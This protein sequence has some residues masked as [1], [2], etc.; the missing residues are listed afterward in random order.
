MTPTPRRFSRPLAALLF[1]LLG[2]VASIFQTSS[3]ADRVN[4]SPALSDSGQLT[5]IGPRPSPSEPPV[6]G[7]SMP[8]FQAPEKPVVKE[9]ILLK[10]AR[11]Q[12]PFIKLHGNLKAESS[13]IKRLPLLDVR[14]KNKPTI[15]K[16]LRIGVVR[17]LSVPL[18]PIS[19]GA[20]YYVSEGEV[21]VAAILSA[22]SLR[23]RLHFTDTSLP[24]GARVFVY[25]MDNPE[26]FYGPYEGH[27]PSEDGTFWTPPLTGEG[28][29]VEYFTPSGA[30]SADPPFKISEISHNYKDVPG[31]TDSAGACNLE[32]S[33]EWANVAKS[34]GMI[35]FVT[36]GFEAV[37]TGTL[38]NDS[39]TS[40]DH[41][42]LTANHC[43]NS[44]SEAQS[45]QIYWNYNSGETPYTFP[46]SFSATLK[47]TG[48]ASDFSLLRFGSVPSGLF[49]SGWDANPVAASTTITG[50]HHPSGSHK[51][52]SF[53]ATNSNCVS[54]LPGPCTNFT[55]V[56][57]NQGVTEPGSSGS[58]IWT[59][60][61]T[62][63]DSKLV[64]TLTGG[65]SACDNLSGADYY[66]RFSVT[67]SNVSAFLNGTT[68]V[69]SINPTS[70]SFSAADGNGS[71]TV[72]APP[73][74]N[75]SVSSTAA[76]LAITSPASGTGNG[77]INF[78]VNANTNLQRR[79]S[80]VVGTQ[81][82]DV[83]QAGGG[84]CA[85]TPIGL[86]QSM[87]GTLAISDC[88]L[89]D[90]TYVDAY[91]FSGT[92][93]Q[94]V[95]ILMTSS[96]FDTY[97]Y[98]L[99]P[100][101]SVLRI[102][103]DLNPGVDTNSRIPATGYFTLPAN[104]TYTILAN[105]FDAGATGAYVLTLTERP[106]QTL[107]LA[108][109]APD[110]GMTITYSPADRSGLTSGITPFTR[111]FYQ[112][113]TVGLSAPATAPNGNILLKWQQDG[114]DYSTGNSIQVSTNTDH[115]ITAVY[116]PI[117][118]FTLTVESS[119]PT[120]GV[121]ITVSPND[122][123]NLGNGSTPFART[124]N[125]FTQ[126]TLTAPI[127][128]GGTYFQK[129]QENGN[130]LTPNRTTTVNM[131]PNRTLTAV[132]VTVP[133]TPTP[134][135]TP[136]PSG[137][138]QAVT[139]LIDPAHT[140]S[141]YD[142]TTP[143]LAQRWSRDLG[144]QIS[145]PLIA[146]G[147]VFVTTVAGLH[148]LDAT[149]GATLWTTGDLGSSPAAAYDAGR[150]FVITSN[151]LL[152]AFDASTGT[153]VWTRQLSGQTFMSPPTAT[154]GTVYVV[155]YPTVHAVSETDG[156]IKWSTANVGGVS[157]SPTVSATAVY[158]A[159]ACTR[160]NA[161]A[162]STGAVLWNRPGSCSGIGGRTA[163]LFGGRLYARFDN[164]VLD[165]G[166]GVQVGEFSSAPAPAF[167]GPTGYFVIGSLNGGTLEARDLTSGNLKW[168]F[169]GDGTL[170]SAPIVVN[171]Y[172]YIGSTS[173]K[174]Y[175]LSES[176]GT[177]VWTGT[178]GAAINPPDE[179][180]SAAPAG[181]A[182]G[183]GVIV[184]P[185]SNRLVAYQSIQSNPVD[186]PD[187]FVR[188]HYLDF[189]G[190]QPD[191]AGLDFWTN[192]ITSCGSNQQCIEV[193]RINVSASFFLSI[194]FKETGYLVERLYKTA[195]GDA[196]GNS[197]FPNAHQLSV[198]I[199]RLN[200][201]LADTQQIGQGVIVGQ[202]NWEQQLETNKQNFIADF[203]QRSRFTTA[204]PTSMTAAQFVDALNAKAGNP[205]SSAERDQLVNE[206]TANAKT[207]AQVLRA[208]AEHPNLLA[209][210]FNRAFVLMQYF[211]Y[212]RRNPNDPQDADYSGYDF[213]LT[214]L[215]QF[216]GNF[217]D[218]EMVKAF[219]TSIEYRQRFGP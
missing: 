97:L 59:G 15:E 13:K 82:F 145:Y 35:D 99:N 25:S 61:G 186:T 64:G 124:Y 169:T 73:G 2:T 171:G 44:Q 151:G 102:N 69:S 132:Y 106:T 78:T 70:Q 75:W 41:Y 191:Q 74:C 202:S 20:L 156:T 127:N 96:A 39:D 160:V 66:G 7:Q 29:V 93:N 5:L 52:I 179:Q 159:L 37:C 50:I 26:E 27:G 68:C 117:P 105:S 147:R 79:G 207:R 81:V 140:G 215:N 111:T 158:I 71:F 163:P 1:F 128:S 188:Q 133:P 168:S 28:V 48:T 113:L 90:G 104:G 109:T 198:P 195:Y 121:P 193:K 212:L 6:A 10:A 58:G 203:V 206:L 197:T 47:V 65:E 208:I 125:R 14:E 98:L 148:A 87:N 142:T 11:G 152:R 54:G 177:N 60:T 176:T 154:E 83:S 53:G 3:H 181:L 101:G 31:W 91:S 80:I 172:V 116:G 143:P 217:I 62:P 55:G 103:D 4:R 32:V 149:T 161:L 40:T 110:S 201:F 72:N 182:A 108:S 43:I 196:T 30:T 118:T 150:V 129:W 178:V 200:E 67:Y 130:D 189:L 135:P 34:V 84:V 16:L 86:G 119:N 22:G 23:T 216:N 139:Y 85:A 190:R 24:S 194:E 56:T 114:V 166:T 126:V 21:R 180:S 199:I 112:N 57:W 131:N 17:Q 153:Q 138:G 157:S 122:N 210:E 170:S 214:K 51:R 184:V 213:W 115:T 33:P 49:Y 136:T 77:T 144:N 9:N 165:A 205:L 167:N 123:G 38:L 89:G 141:Q 46:A 146:G 36:G 12:A 185:A 175:A 187:F 134:T 192:E 92:A 173:G 137:P 45:A 63:A 8:G 155:G 164:A 76:W 18:D 204:L 88:S 183:E 19:D 120:S 95:S 209:S 107:T 94:Q 211:G 174:L 100:D 42:V 218:A 162:P 219:I